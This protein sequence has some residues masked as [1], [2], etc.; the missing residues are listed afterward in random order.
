MRTIASWLWTALDLFRTQKFRFAL[1]VSGIVV[2]VGS[3]IVMASL[4][5]VG[6]EV[7]Q[8]SSTEITGTDV[9]TVS[10][11]WTVLRNNADATALEKRDLTALSESQTLPSDRAIGAEYGPNQQQAQYAGE[12]F[13][14][15]VM[16][17]APNTLQ[18]RHL[19]IA[20]GRALTTDEFDQRR[21]VI[22]AGA[23]VGKGKVKPGQTIRIRGV[24]YVVVGV[25]AEKP[26]M[27]PGGAWSWNNRLLMPST[28][29]RLQ[30]EPAGKP[31]QIVV[32]VAPPVG[33][34]GLIKDYV[35]A[36]RDVVDVVLSSDRT[37]RSWEFEGASDD[38]NTE[39]IIFLT[40][41][42]LLYLTTVFSM[43]VG[44][45]NIMNIML[46]TVTERTREIG[47]RRALGATQRDVMRQFLGETV[48]VT[49]VGAVIGVVG[50]IALVALGTGAMATW[51]TAWPFRIVPWSLIGGVAFA[52]IIG[53]VFGL[54]PAWRAS[55]LDP[56][57]ALRME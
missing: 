27:G 39:E 49:L 16:G 38:S 31:R 12:D 54:Y 33:Y 52:S 5:D 45:I 9:V 17:V 48:M 56:V 24:P 15:F 23:N 53:L 36:A 41:E 29:Y 20:S 37:V 57:E 55:R 14:P 2:G 44:G 21:R 3:L 34:D 10:N 19:A 28:T 43:L 25:L 1:T 47:T 18:L 6:Q 7:L 11:D 8:R 35:L 46:V 30:F 51:V 42:V 40:I 22:L 13:T 32:Q 4:L 26:E 50:G